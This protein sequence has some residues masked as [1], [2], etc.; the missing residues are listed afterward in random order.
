MVS[1]ND[2]CQGKE[3]KQRK[4]RE[5][6][7]YPQVWFS[8]AR[9]LEAMAFYIQDSLLCCAG[10]TYFSCGIVGDQ[11]MMACDILRHFLLS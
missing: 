3:L 11:T 9:C 4:L 1:V 5:T 8:F 10:I 2:D 6:E 7:T